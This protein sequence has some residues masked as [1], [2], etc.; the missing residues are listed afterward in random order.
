MHKLAIWKLTPDEQWVANTELY[1]LM[2][3]NYKYN[4]TLFKMLCITNINATFEHAKVAEAN[5]IIEY[6]KTIG[7]ES[8]LYDE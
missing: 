2:D 7:G 8:S 5:E 1:P 4:K 6:W 3:P